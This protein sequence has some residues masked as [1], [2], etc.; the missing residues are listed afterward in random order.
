M[1]ETIL[2]VEND[3]NNRDKEDRLLLK[4]QVYF[5]TS[6]TFNSSE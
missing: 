4:K 6:L 1:G 3:V 2:L 5:F